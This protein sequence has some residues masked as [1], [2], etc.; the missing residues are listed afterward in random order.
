MKFSVCIDSVFRNIDPAT[1]LEGV[2][3]GGFDQYEFWGWWNKDLD[4]LI[5][6]ARELSL[7]CRA[8]CTRF[9]PLTDPAQREAYL[10]GLKE[11]I[12][13]AKKFGVR[14]IITQIGADTGARREFQHTSVVAGLK[15][16]APILKENDMTLVIEP[17]NRRYENPNTFCEF[18]DEGF[19][20][21]DETGSEN[22]KLLFDTYHQQIT[23]G[24]IIN[25]SVARIKQIGHFHAAGNPNRYELYDGELNYKKVF[26]AIEA[27]GYQGFMGLEHKPTGNPVEGLKRI[28]EYVNQK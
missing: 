2:K 18:S 1:A 20:M 21:L 12:E 10:D 23:E 16:C 8:F 19:E 17:V 24:D 9:I 25:R 5:K 3:E 15:A 28:K 26:A 4:G 27:A 11:T 6:K 13:T 7:V 14:I 22:V